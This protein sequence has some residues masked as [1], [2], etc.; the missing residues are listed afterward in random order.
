MVH[1]PVAN[2]TIE[3]AAQRS[4]KPVSNQTQGLVGRSS[5]LSALNHTTEQTSHQSNMTNPLGRGRP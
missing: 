4:R 5:G 1:D 2:T 3:E